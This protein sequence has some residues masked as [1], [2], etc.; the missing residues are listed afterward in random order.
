V[1]HQLPFSC[2]E[3]LYLIFSE[4]GKNPSGWLS[5]SSFL[6]KLSIFYS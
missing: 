4:I 1:S 2:T 5:F 3:E 6:N